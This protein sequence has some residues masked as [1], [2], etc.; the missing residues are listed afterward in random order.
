MPRIDMGVGCREE[1]SNWLIRLPRRQALSG[2]KREF[3]DFGRSHPQ[4]T[5][6]NQGFEAN[7]GGE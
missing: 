1:G 2:K 3:E 7:W 5:D 6:L 4:E